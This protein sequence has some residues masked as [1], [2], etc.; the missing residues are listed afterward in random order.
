MVIGLRPSDSVDC[1]LILRGGKESDHSSIWPYPQ[2]SVTIV[3]ENSPNDIKR[4]PFVGGSN[5]LRN[6]GAKKWA[7]N[8]QF[9]DKSEICDT[10]VMVSCL[11]CDGVGSMMVGSGWLGCYLDVRLKHGTFFLVSKHKELGFSFNSRFHNIFRLSK[12]GGYEVYHLNCPFTC[13]WHAITRIKKDW[14]FLL[15]KF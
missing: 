1:G 9:E 3:W 11:S 2:F 12:Q 15:I 14:R 7:Q 8:K 4:G 5:N 10:C 13:F 6:Q